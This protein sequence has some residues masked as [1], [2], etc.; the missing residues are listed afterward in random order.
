MTHAKTP[1]KV[2]L[3]ALLLGGCVQPMTATPEAPLTE[4]PMVIDQAM[5]VR[6]WDRSAAVYTNLSFVAGSPG[7]WYQ[8]KWNEPDWTYAVVEA[9]L[10]L[11]QAL[12][13][14]ITVWFPP[15]WE[16]VNYAGL[17]MAPTYHAMPPL[18]PSPAEPVSPA[19]APQ[20]VPEPAD[21]TAPLPTATPPDSPQPS[22]G[23][24]P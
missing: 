9:P 23:P 1:A 24:M 17:K 11:G 3:G 13:L 10:F 15:Q 2:A 7:F 20:P 8:P 4:E 21:A 14:P 6:D 18:R 12:I 22:P 19:R 16:P 5:Q